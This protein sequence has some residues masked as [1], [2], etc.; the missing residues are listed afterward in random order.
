MGRHVARAE[1]YAYSGLPAGTHV[2]L[3][4][5]T[6]TLVISLDAPLELSDGPLGPSRRR[7]DFSVA[8]LHTTPVTIHHDGALRGLQLDL[9][10]AGCRA[11]IGCPAGEL[12]DGAHEGVDVIGAVA[13]QLR[14][15]LHQPV[16]RAGQLRLVATALGAS[17]RTAPMDERLARAWD[18]L[19]RAHG[20]VSVAELAEDAG[21]STRHFTQRFTQEFG[22][23]PKAMAR[24]I[25]FGRSRAMLGHGI[26]AAEVAARCGYADQAHL[27]REWRRLAG[28]TPS[29][30]DEDGD[31][32][33]VQDGEHAGGAA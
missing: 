20:L 23:G 32:A 19:E 33:F 28:T 3:P 18:H 10:P 26:P 21:W 27:V 4:S 15:Q 12:A 14:E 17:P 1:S 8:G 31:L 29:H 2:G 16:D 24:V 25:R 9:T 7:F 13:E 11:L 5:S 30:W 22:Q 6:L